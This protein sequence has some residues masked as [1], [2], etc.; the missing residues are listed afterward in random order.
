MKATIAE[1]KRPVISVAISS[2][3]FGLETKVFESL[4]D[5]YDWIKSNGVKKYEA[6]E[7]QFIY[8][9]NTGFECAFFYGPQINLEV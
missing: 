5:M 7:K 9:S 6:K 2:V 1:V 3:Q 4:I 8:L